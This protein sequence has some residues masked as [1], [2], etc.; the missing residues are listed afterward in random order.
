MLGLDV[1]N[2]YYD[3]RLKEAR[4]ARSTPHPCYRHERVELT[5]RPE[6]QRVFREHA[7]ARNASC[8]WRRRLWCGDAA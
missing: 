2:D 1:L 4:L 8:T 5:D 6:A 7:T 3:V